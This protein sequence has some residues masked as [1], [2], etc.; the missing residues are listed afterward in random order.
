VARAGELDDGEVHV[1]SI[2]REIR[3]LDRLLRF[4]YTP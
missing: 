4:N 3:D 1:L 2:R